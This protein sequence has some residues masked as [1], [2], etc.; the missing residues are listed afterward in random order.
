MIKQSFNKSSGE[1]LAEKIKLLSD[2]LGQDRIKMGEDMSYHTYSKLG[3]VAEYFFIATTKKELV[4]IL[5]LVN[6]LKVRYFVFGNGTK[7]LV[8]EQG[9]DGLVIKNRADAI[10]IGGIKGKVGREGIGIEEAL[11]EVDSGL[12]L[13]K[14]NDYL[15]SQKLKEFD[16]RVAKAGTVG[17]SF[18]L[19]PQLQSASQRIEVWNNGEVFEK[20]IIDLNRTKDIILSVV[21]KVRAKV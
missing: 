3:G 12:S 6:E 10:K 18:F 15:K 8:S 1:V 17:G 5:N 20:E 21:F 2:T 9:I 14:L 11:I 19:D 4:Q 13:I 7:I 16:L